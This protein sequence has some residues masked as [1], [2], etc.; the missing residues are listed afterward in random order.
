MEDICGAPPLS[1]FS[2]KRN[3]HGEQDGNRKSRRRDGVKRDGSD[4]PAT[5]G[6]G[7]HRC[8]SFLPF[9]SLFSCSFP[10]I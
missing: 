8:S 10:L 9:F 6:S 5:D 2:F 1:L 3:F 4:R 7:D